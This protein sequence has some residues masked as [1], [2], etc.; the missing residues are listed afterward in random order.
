MFSYIY[1]RTVSEYFHLI[2]QNIIRSSTV[3]IAMNEPPL[4]PQPFEV[5]GP[6]NKDFKLYLDTSL[7]QVGGTRL[8]DLYTG[9]F[10]VS[11]MPPNF[12]G[13]LGGHWNQ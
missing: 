5:F 8:V 4:L 7:V 11:R 2:L 9:I 13:T 3:V 6:P 12:L 1:V 10:H